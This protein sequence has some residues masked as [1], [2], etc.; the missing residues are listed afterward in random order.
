MVGEG[1]GGL[2][3]A[4][5]LVVLVWASEASTPLSWAPTLPLSDNCF[6]QLAGQI[7]D[8]SC[9]VPVPYV[10]VITVFN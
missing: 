9:Q 8:C 1:R 7:D 10:Q 2:A 3:L 6:C 5:L 4:L